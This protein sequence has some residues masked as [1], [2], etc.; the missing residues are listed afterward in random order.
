M[1]IKGE[2]VVG[3]GLII[4]AGAGVFWPYGIAVLL[5]W[6]LFLI[7]LPLLTIGAI[8]IRDCATPR[9]RAAGGIVLLWS[10]AFGLFGAPSIVWV[11]SHVSLEG[12]DVVEVIQGLIVFVASLSAP[13][14]FGVGLRMTA[15]FKPARC[16][17][18]ALAV[19][20]VGLAKDVAATCLG[21][22][23]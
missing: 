10:A 16:V 22:M 4:V 7:G 11:L 21:R 1:W 19:V 9:W 5:G 15:N 12:A 6:P 2:K 20:A 3:A 17:G 14:L 8:R 18:W 13:F 23:K